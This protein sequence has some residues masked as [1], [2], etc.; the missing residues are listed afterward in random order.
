MSGPGFHRAPMRYLAAGLI[1]N[2]KMNNAT[3]WLTPEPEQDG[4]RFMAALGLGLALEFAAL[5]VL[6]PVL[7][8]APAATPPSVVKLTIQ[9]PPP[10]KPAPPKPVTPPPPPVS[11]PPKPVTPPKPVPTPRPAMHH[12]V[13]HLPP[14]PKHV[15]PPPPPPPVT[16]PAPSA[17]PAPPAPSPDQLGLFRQAMRD[18]VQAVANQVYPAAAQMT[19]QG[20]SAEVTF[21]YNDGQV[22]GIALTRSSGYPLLD[23]AA[24]LAARVAH[25]PLPPQGF[26]G[27]T[28]SVT[29]EVIFRPAAT[30]VDGD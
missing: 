9:N 7:H 6:V 30:S 28:Y 13:R 5:A 19:G 20:G 27:R 14:P 15:A 17:P 2:F 25:Y 21:T 10:P 12:V 4:R 3:M 11:Q 18:A 8:H 29:V 24:L 22:T 23:Q 16:P 26:A 1:G